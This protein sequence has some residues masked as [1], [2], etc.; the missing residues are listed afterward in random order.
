MNIEYNTSRPHLSIS[1]YGRHIQKMIKSAIAIEDKEK[2]NKMAQVIV[3]TM[4]QLSPQSKD[5]GDF[6]QKIWDHLFILSDFKLDVD[7][8]YPKPTKDSIVFKPEPVTYPLYT[9]NY[10]Y[11]GK[12]IQNIIKKMTTL[13]PGSQRDALVKQVANQMKKLYLTWNRDSVTDEIIKAHLA[14][15][16]GNI[17]TLNEEEK[18]NKTS[19]ILASSAKKAKHQSA[20]SSKYAKGK[21]GH[22]RRQNGQ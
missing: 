2:R 9:V 14:D 10:R 16:S 6:W 11:Y 13:E 21:K 15:L 8:P 4:G 18:L 19:V 1:E 5:S 3:R 7:S 17:L 22:Y 20:K 12:N